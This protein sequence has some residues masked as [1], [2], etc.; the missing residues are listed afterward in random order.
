[1]NPTAALDLQL[2]VGRPLT[3]LQI[4]TF[5]TTANSHVSGLITFPPSLD[6]ELARFL[7]KHYGIEHQEQPHALPP[8]KFA[9]AYQPFLV[10][11][12]LLKP[13]LLLSQICFS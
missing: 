8:P 2:R 13:R 6:S 1:M 9:E 12:T 5:G 3:Q 10:R 4:C 11:T 7:L